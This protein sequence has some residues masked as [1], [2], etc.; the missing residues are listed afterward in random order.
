MNDAKHR[1][2]L[3]I[4]AKMKRIHIHISQ[5]EKSMLFH[6]KRNT[7]ESRK[8]LF[9]GSSKCSSVQYT[10]CINGSITITEVEITNGVWI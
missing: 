1:M 10:P 6:S 3:Y 9:Q 2:E 4:I 7:R 5:F 8:L